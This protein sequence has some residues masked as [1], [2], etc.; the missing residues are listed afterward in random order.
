MFALGIPM[1]GGLAGLG[2]MI[3]CLVFPHLRRFALAALVSP[4]AA[5]VVFFIGTLIIADMQLAADP[6]SVFTLKGYE[7]GPTTFDIWL[8][9]GSPVV[10]FL[11]SIPLFV[12]VQQFAW[13]LLR[14]AQSLPKGTHS[15]LNGG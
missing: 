1:L 4:F 11:V 12:K 10:T 14:P 15:G 8:Y 3:F 7:H 9:F 2:A 5:S 13:R 6:G